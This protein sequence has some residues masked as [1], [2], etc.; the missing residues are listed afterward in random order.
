MNSRRSTP[1]SIFARTA[2]ILG[3]TLFL[4]TAVVM[5][6][7][8]SLALFPVAKR[9]ADD[10]AALLVLSAKTWTEL[11]PQ[12]RPDFI[13]ELQQEHDIRLAVADKELEPLQ[14]HSLMVYLGLLEK[15]LERRL[16]QDHVV[17]GRDED[18]PDGVWIRLPSV[19]G[20]LYFGI[21]DTRIGARPP[22][23]FLIALAAI[24]LFSLAAALIIARRITRPLERLSDATTAVGQGRRELLSVEGA[25]AREIQALIRNFN[26]MTR[27]VGE[28]LENRTTLLA[29]I[30]HDLRTPL[31]RLRLGLEIHGDALE[32]DLRQL[33][34]RNLEE[35]EQLLDQSLMLARGFD[36]KE[37]VVERE[38]VGLLQTLAAQREAEWRQQHPDSP[39][40]LR[41]EMDAAVGDE[42]LWELPEQACLRVLHNLID[43]ALRYGDGD[44][45]LRLERRNGCPLIRVLDRGPG[46]PESQREAVFRPF[47]RLESSRNAATGGSGLG[48]AIV[49][50]LCQALG[51]RVDLQAREGGG[52]EARLWLCGAPGGSARRGPV[53]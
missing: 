26:R 5:A 37:P 2:R 29:G 50:Q 12:T 31:T 49:R 18:N 15:A 35:M 39:G 3:L 1:P 20:P 10:L 36:G 16:D 23:V 33:L 13:Q 6:T 7:S 47:H 9:S 17:V 44:V 51:W 22:L 24:L 40:Q 48:L 53:E 21:S 34:Q 4:L 52:T 8:I 14:R 46:I 27:Q 42:W 30:S 19:E 28:L 25:E 11:P 45:L 32:P 38:L 41:F 43:N